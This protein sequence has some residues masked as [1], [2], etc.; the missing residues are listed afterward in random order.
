MGM[1]A[2][3]RLL[4]G[5]SYVST[6]SSFLPLKCCDEVFMG[7]TIGY[8]NTAAEVNGCQQSTPSSKFIRHCWEFTSHQP[9][10]PSFIGTFL[11]APECYNAAINLLNES[12]GLASE[13]YQFQEVGYL[14]VCVPH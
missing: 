5:S 11:Q 13:L 14:L 12:S 10:K 6:S 8:A 4:K 1:F 2:R 9:M 3:V 7:Q